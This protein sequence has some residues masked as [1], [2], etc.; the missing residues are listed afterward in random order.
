ML[1]CVL[2]AGCGEA[3]DATAPPTTKPAAAPP[4]TILEVTAPKSGARAFRFDVKSLRAKP[5][6]IELRLRNDDT[7]AH[8]IRIQD[9]AECCDAANDVGGT[10]TISP[11]RS[12]TARVKLTPGRYWFVCSIGGHYDGDTG[13]MKGRLVVG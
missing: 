1:V 11:A 9:G 7:D 8:N 2:G 12:E 6:T 3:D 10:N 4:S 5:G 13:K